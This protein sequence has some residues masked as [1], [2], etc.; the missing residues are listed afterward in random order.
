MPSLDRG[1]PTR[2]PVEAPWRGLSREPAGVVAREADGCQRVAFGQRRHRLVARSCA[3][4]RG[5]VTCE[6]RSQGQRAAIE[7]DGYPA[8]YGSSCPDVGLSGAAGKWRIGIKFPGTATDAPGCA[9][10]VT[11]LRPESHSDCQAVFAS[12]LA[13]D[14]VLIDAGA[15]FTSSGSRSMRRISARCISSQIAIEP[16]L[17]SGS[18]RIDRRTS[19]WSE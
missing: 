2:R 8:E 4:G 6:F 3:S 15:C 9:S 17:A 7:P 19:P 1:A 5:R 11:I 13:L 18:S 14:R 10:A 16:G 12:A